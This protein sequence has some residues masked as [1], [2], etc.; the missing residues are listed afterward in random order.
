MPVRLARRNYAEVLPAYVAQLSL[1]KFSPRATMNIPCNLAFAVA[2]SL[3]FAATSYA[4][5]GHDE[6]AG[7]TESQASAGAAVML[8][9]IEGPRPWTAKPV[10]NDA[11]R[12]QIA[13]VTDRTG[14]HRPGVWMDAVRKLNRLRPEFVVSV[15]DLI[16]G[17]TGD[18]AQVERE[19]KEFTGFVDKLDMRFF[20]V[21]GNHDLTNPMMHKV[22]REKFGPEWYSFD[23]KQVHFVCL[24]SEDPVQHMGE[25]QL[26]WLEKDLAENAEA[27][28][29]LV[30]IHKPL[31]SYAE[32]D[33]A[34]G[35]QDK[36]NW[37]RVEKMLVDRPHTI[38]AGHVHHY[39]QYK[40]NGRDYYSLATTGGG[41]QLRG[42]EY[43][44]FDHVMWLTMEEDGPH[45]ANIRLDGILAPNVVTEESIARFNR[46]LAKT[47]ISVEPI[48]IENADVRGF[49]KGEI[50][51][52]LVNEFDEP[53]AMRGAIDGLPLRGITVAPQSL[54]LAAGPGETAELRVQVEF[55]DPVDFEMLS[56]T[57]L[58]AKLRS[59]A[60]DPLT[61]E[62]VVPVVID[63]R[64]PF[65]SLAEMPAIDGTIES[66]PEESTSTP[67]QPLLLGNV[68]SWQGNSDG[69]TEFFARHVNDKIYVAAR[70]I[71][72]R[73]TPG[74]RVEL[75][76]DPRGV[77]A[78]SRDPRYVGTGLSI[79]AFAPVKDGE[80][81][82]DA[83]R[84][85]SDKAYANVEAKSKQTDAGYD[86]EFAIPVDLAKQ[87]QG[88][89]WHS[90][91]STVVLHD[92]DDADEDP[93]QI[94]WRGGQDLREVNTGFGH[95]VRQD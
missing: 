57:T 55:T 61:S 46:Y 75:L 50:A 72:D 71:D 3:V 22:W 32:R 82:V 90:I 63:R 47:A 12:F 91:Q 37:K 28:W 86:V 18:R 67:E 26:T 77:A 80:T 31:W 56:R 52:R 95:F 66:W 64:Y 65:P 8:P 93:T 39:V 84:M 69:S 20:F 92:A 6:L 14:G 41:S 89:D 13:I 21:A 53:V 79:S 35:N 16:E 2:F 74:D 48:L 4:H 33:L 87:I 5:P 78:R 25:E 73:L 17:Y 10:L 30:F 38:F 88:K 23:Y 58:T 54:E 49:S 70:V 34:A 27:R 51:I 83:H 62:Q 85:S 40:R 36:T 76:I 44:E 9:K 81:K 24:N 45:L 7:S 29:T 59:T 42:N 15:G 1:V 19:W 94:V 43:G 68:G 11:N 60:G